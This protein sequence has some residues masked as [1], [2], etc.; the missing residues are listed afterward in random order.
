[1]TTHDTFSLNRRMTV[2]SM[3]LWR[4]LRVLVLLV[5]KRETNPQ[6]ATPETAT[7]YAGGEFDLNM[8]LDD[9]KAEKRAI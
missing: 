6:C 7:R 3:D 8:F 9:K 2:W 1:M 4:N 5:V